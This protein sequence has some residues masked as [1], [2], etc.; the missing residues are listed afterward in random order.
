MSTPRSPVAGSAPVSVLLDAGPIAHQGAGL[1][2][3]AT[4]LARH[5]WLAQRERLTLNL[6]YNAHS[7]HQMPDSL[8]EVPQVPWPMGQY[9]WR[10]SV[11]ASQLLR[12]RGY[13]RRLPATDVYH[14]TEH[15]L[16]YL[17]RRT[18]LTVHDLI[19]RHLPQTHTWKNRTFLNVGMPLF[20]RR[21]DAIIAVSAQTK[22]DLVDMY[23]VEADKITVIPEGIDQDRFRPVDPGD[24]LHRDLQARYGSYLLMVGTLEPRKNHA[25]ALRA[26][27]RLR[28]CGQAQH[29]VIVG[30]TGWKFSPVHQMVRDLELE[31]SV[32]F[33]GYIPDEAL[34]TYY[35]AALALLQPSLYEGF[36]FP[37]L[38]AMACGTPVVAS[39][40]SS[41]PELAGDSALWID[42]DNDQQLARIIQDLAQNPTLQSQLCQ[43]G[44]QHVAP[45]TWAE[46]SRQTT[47]L[48]LS[49]V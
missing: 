31:E 28:A 35:S 7:G 10:L 42:P 2:R 4:E 30:G 15:L 49:L 3:Y 11:L 44:L 47:D 8:Q 18:V 9:V 29:L 40:R 39:N 12:H 45:Y 13:E 14:A 16:P 17:A 24:R 46:T 22:R 48:Y 26:L 19:F 33:M 6:F 34:P 21:A 32:S 41:L 36:G 5:L 23:R 37:V 27:A 43:K 20:T 25:V 38:E 1:G